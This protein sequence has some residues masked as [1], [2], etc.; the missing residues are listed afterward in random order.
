[1]FIQYQ[2][3]TTPARIIRQ[4]QTPLHTKTNRMTEHR[5]MLLRF[6]LRSSLR[7]VTGLQLLQ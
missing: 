7:T 1:M 3:D 5:L 4:F 6:Q 2:K